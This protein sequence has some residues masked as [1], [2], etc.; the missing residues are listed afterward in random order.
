MTRLAELASVIRSKNAG[1]Y[2]LTFDIM[3]DATDKFE[4]VR[5][6]GVLTPMLFAELYSVE[7]DR[8]VSTEY[9]QAVMLKFTIPRRVVA[10][11][12]RDTDVTG[13]QQAFPLYDLDIP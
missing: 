1:P 6:S 8:V 9:E 12:L 2:Q 10:G 4:R 13:G 11:D 5:R 7:P 3:F